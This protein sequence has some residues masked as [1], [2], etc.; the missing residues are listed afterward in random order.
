MK[1]LY[2]KSKVTVLHRTLFTIACITLGAGGIV[3]GLWT[4]KSE[5][6]VQMFC[7]SHLQAT[8]SQLLTYC[9][10]RPTQPPTF[11]GT[12]NQ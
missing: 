4:H 5:V 11:S 6:T 8:L 9:V 7:P 10:L 12:G 1:R 3:V 2:I